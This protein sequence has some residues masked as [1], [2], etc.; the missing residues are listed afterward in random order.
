LAATVAHI[1]QIR[2]T[3]E[4]ADLLTS[5]RPSTGP[6]G[7]ALVP[8]ALLAITVIGGLLR[9][10]QIGF[11]SL[12]IDEAFSVWM[13]RQ[14]IPE[15]LSWLIRIDQ[16]PPLYYLLLRFWMQVGD[17]VG[18]MATP[19]W[20]ATWVRALSALASTLNIPVLYVLG[21]RLTGRRM[22]LLAAL[23]LALSP[24]HVYLAQEARMYALFCLNVSLALLALA[25]LLTT[26]PLNPPRKPGGR[27]S[28]PPLGAPRRAP[29]G[30][31][32]RGPF[33]TAY[34]LFTA[35]ALWTHNTA[36][37]FFAAVNLYVLGLMLTRRH[38]SST[39]A[40]TLPCCALA[41]PPLRTWIAAQACVL[42]LWSPWM[43]PFIRQATGV[44][45]EFWLPAPTWGT[46]AGTIHSMM[47]GFLP[48]DTPAG[49][50]ALWSLYSA[51]VLLGVYR[52]RKRPAVLVL[53]ATLF[54]TP[55]AG[56]LLASLRRPIFYDRTLIWA[57]IPLYLLFATGTS[58][59]QETGYL[60]R[61]PVSPRTCPEIPGKHTWSCRWTYVLAIS[62]LIA[63]NVLSLRKYYLHFQKEQWDDAAA[64]V[65]QRVQDGELV[66][67]H[68]SWAQLPF[69]FYFHTERSIKKRG[70]PVD[71][72]DRGVLE[73]KMT[74][75]DLPRLY[76]L[77][78]GHDRIWLVYSHNWYTDPHNLIPEALTG[79]ATILDRR[80]FHGLEVHL[81][82]PRT[83]RKGNH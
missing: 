67:F 37:F 56:E 41:P 54:V 35:A 43:K 60:Q 21:R 5:H 50:A 78:R 72:F 65:A 14:P 70:L 15:M 24:F 8:T 12:W 76:E 80:Q 82:G 45:R 73:P 68:A 40:S 33:W 58:S 53:L 9:A 79:Y 69:D 39:R 27:Q 7:R 38:R 19:E 63:L 28:T 4:G 6:K 83:G 36:L 64:Y 66:L 71:L 2:I 13:G 52:L 22:G 46:V 25:H 61:N 47:S 20:S 29:R 77:I 31:V 23:V 49:T 55:I 81:Y 42:L 32:G 48:S 74:E 3:F 34:V 16:H 30:G 1:A 51:I 62:L 10:Y 57:S 59:L 26:P 11:K 17:A 18:R 75:N 44:Y